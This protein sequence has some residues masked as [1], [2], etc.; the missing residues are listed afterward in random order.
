MRLAAL[1]VLTASAWAA[2]FPT[3]LRLL[4]VAAGLDY[5]VLITHAGDGSGRQFIIEQ[6]G[7]IRVL[8]NGIVAQRPFLDIRNK[9][10]CCGEQG[11]LGL[12]FPSNFRQNRRFYV[13]Y[14]NLPSGNTVIARYRVSGDPDVADPASEEILLTI[15]QPFPNHNGGGIAF[16]PRDGRLYIGMGDGGSAGD[17]MNNAQRSDSLLGKM[18]RLDVE[19]GPG[20]DTR[21]EIWSRGLRNPWR[22]SFDRETGDLWIGDVGQNA[23]EEIDF[24]PAASQGGENYGWRRMEGSQCYE[25]NCDRTGLTMPVFDYGRSLGFSVTGGYVYRGL[26]YP[27]IRGLY[28]F[29]DYGSG[30]LWGIRASDGNFETR[31][32]QDTN[33][34]VSSF[35]EDEQGEIYIIHHASPNG[36]IY[37]LAASGPAVTATGVVNA[38]SYAQGLVPGGIASI[39]GLGLTPINGIA[40]AASQPLPTALQG[41]SVTVNGVPAPLFAVANVQGQEQ[42]NFLVPAEAENSQRARIVVTNNGLAGSAVEVDVRPV[43]PG[44]FAAIRRG[45]FLEI[46]GTGFGGATPTVTVGGSA[47]KVTFAGRAPGFAGLTQINVALPSGAAAGAEIIATAG[48]VSSN[49]LRL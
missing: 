20:A 40:N 14:T 30:N 6:P 32:L 2:D 45:D 11:L 18:L 47:A 16:G 5:P 19:G 10:L 33:L 27:A 46:Y 41:T 38:A 26:R 22:F 35:G 48:G 21:P 1:L 28:F 8:K 37:V 3:D 42:I 31:L 13:N 34:S 25:Q 12:A 9:V 39:F 7:R 23:R 4:P 24:Q 36:A 44:L 15:T 49:A 29:A 43:Q 17:P